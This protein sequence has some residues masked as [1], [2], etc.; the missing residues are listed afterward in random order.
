MLLTNLHRMFLTRRLLAYL[1][2]KLAL[3]VPINFHP[4]KIN[5]DDLRTIRC[6]D[7]VI[8]IFRRRF[9]DLINLEPLTLSEIFQGSDLYTLR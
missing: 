1:E 4:I 8:D 3:F 2:L 9:I 5:D 6:F 7:L